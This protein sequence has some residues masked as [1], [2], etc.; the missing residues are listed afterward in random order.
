M[1]YPNIIDIQIDLFI[2]RDTYLEVVLRALENS[3]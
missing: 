1:L 3:K 2:T